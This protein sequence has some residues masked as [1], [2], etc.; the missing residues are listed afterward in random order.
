MDTE[1]ECLDDAD[2]CGLLSWS[3]SRIVDHIMDTEVSC[4]KARKSN[5][6][7]AIHLRWAWIGNE[8]I[9]SFLSNSI[10]REIINVSGGSWGSARVVQSIIVLSFADV[11]RE[12]F[13]PYHRP[14][15]HFLYEHLRH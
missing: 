15:L 6:S 11:N 4:L 3:R 7:K 14:Y 2:G 10:L 8:N 1:R 5:F 9:K 13:G 12:E